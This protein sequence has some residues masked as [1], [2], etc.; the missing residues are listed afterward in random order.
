MPTTQIRLQNPDGTFALA[1]VDDLVDD[2]LR[3]DYMF[4]IAVPRIP[5]RYSLRPK[6]TVEY[7]SAFW[8]GYT[9][10]TCIP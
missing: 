10:P 7:D 3:K 4:D 8:Q 9:S 1:H 5:L 6:H 2:M